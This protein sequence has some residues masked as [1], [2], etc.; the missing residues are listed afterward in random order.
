MS[1][2]QKKMDFHDDGIRNQDRGEQKDST[3]RNDTE[4]SGQDENGRDH[5]DA[6]TE[7]AGKEEA[8]GLR[9]SGNS[10]TEPNP[11]PKRHSHDN[12][13]TER[14]PDSASDAPE[15]ESQAETGSNDNEKEAEEQDDNFSEYEHETSYSEEQEEEDEILDFED[16]F[17]RAYT[18]QNRRQRPRHSP[19]GVTKGNKSIRR[20]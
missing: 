11:D 8:E 4:N 9:G 2:P 19:I 16:T 12:Q 17:Y 7:T 14:H 6:S 5:G 1:D 3:A 10:T 13:D 15:P 18:Y 20:L